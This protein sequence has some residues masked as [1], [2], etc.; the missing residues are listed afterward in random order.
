MHRQLCQALDEV[1]SADAYQEAKVLVLTG[2]GR[3][4]C[5]GQD[6]HDEGLIDPQKPCI[7]GIPAFD[8]GRMV[9]E[10]YIPLV[11]KLQQLRLPTLCAV[12]GIAAGAGSSIALAC[13]LVVACQ[14][15]SFVQSFAKIGLIPDSG[16]T[17]FLPRKVGLARA[18]GLAMLAEKLTAAEA[19]QWGLIWKTVADA[20]L[21]ASAEKIAQQLAKMPPS[22]LLHIRTLMREGMTTPLDQQLRHEAKSMR[23]LG[24]SEGFSEGVRAFFEKR[25]R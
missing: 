12:N 23:E 7:D 15:A 13:D 20:E 6:L 10:H 1:Q 9:E 21:L 25:P 8:L 16:G 22:A 5:A 18:M 19:E 14:S 11:Q 24:K 3:G 4:F 17:W 2:A